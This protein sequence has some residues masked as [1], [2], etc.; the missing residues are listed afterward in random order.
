MYAQLA[1]WVSFDYETMV[2]LM[3]HGMAAAKIEVAGPQSA[4]S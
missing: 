1:V 2:W 4:P 3:Y